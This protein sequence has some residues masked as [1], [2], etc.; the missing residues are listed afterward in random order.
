VNKF[1][2]KVITFIL[3]AVCFA[4]PSV[5]YA[6]S[7]TFTGNTADSTGNLGNFAAGFIYNYVAGATT[8]T[9]TADMTNTSPL[10]NGGYITGFA[11]NTPNN[12]NVTLTGGTNGAFLVQYSVSASPFGDFGIGVALG[13]NFLGGGSPLSGIPVG[14]TAEFLF[15]VTGTADTLAQLS[16]SSFTGTTSSSGGEFSIVRFRGFN[17]QGSDKVPGQIVA[18]QITVTPEPNVMALLVVGL[19][20]LVT[21]NRTYFVEKVCPLWRYRTFFHLH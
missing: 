7:I 20:C 9:L 13:G 15:T 16:A 8:A 2:F 4:Y 1:P 10:A 21:F 17:N 14:N 19:I 6:S 11:F 12:V 3:F 5:N 18:G